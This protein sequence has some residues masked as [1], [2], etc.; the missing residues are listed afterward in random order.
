MILFPNLLWLKNNI[1]IHSAINW[2]IYF[3]QSNFYTDLQYSHPSSFLDVTNTVLSA[4]QIHKE[5]KRHKMHILGNNEH[6][7]VFIGI[8]MHINT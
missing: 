5:I 1:H 6:K 4:M 3:F 2:D 8:N 7:N